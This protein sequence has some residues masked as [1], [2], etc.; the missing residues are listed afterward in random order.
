M[1]EVVLGA[2]GKHV[3]I[4]TLRVGV[5]TVNSGSRDAVEYVVAGAG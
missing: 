5:S 2:T 1:D 3:A 4:E